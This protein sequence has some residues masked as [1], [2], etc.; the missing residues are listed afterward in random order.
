MERLK[1]IR[2]DIAFQIMVISLALICLLVV[3]LNSNQ[4]RMASPIPQ[5]ITGEYSQNGG[6]WHALDEKTNL[7][8]LEGDVVIRG[9]LNVDCLE[10][11][12]LYFYRNHIAV[13]FYVNGEDC[14]I[15]AQAYYDPIFASM[16]GEEWYFFVSTGISTED[17]VEI[18]LS[19]PHKFGNKSAY[20]DFL[21]TLYISPN[22]ADTLRHYLEPYSR[23]FM[24]AGIIF[25][26]LAMMLIGGAVAAAALRVPVGRRL[27]KIG[28]LTRFAGGYFLLDVI[29]L[30]FWSNLLV[31]NTYA[32]LLCAILFV[33]WLRLS[34]MDELT[35]Q[36]R[37]VALFVVIPA[38]LLDGLCILLS[39]VGAVLL[40]D[41][42][43]C[44]TVMQIAACLVLLACAVLELCHG[45]NGQKRLIAYSLLMITVLLDIAGVGQNLY[46]SATCTKIAFVAVAVLTLVWI[47]KVVVMD[48][49]A[50]VRAAQLERE[51]ED[52]R[53]AIMLSQIQ[54]HF[55]YN[56]LNAIYYLCGKEPE[57][58]Q[59][60]ISSFSDYLRN[61]M[62]ALEKKELIPF[63]EELQ[64]VQ[65]YLKLEKMRFGEELVVV[66]SIETSGFSLPALTVQP[67]VENAVKH[68]LSKKRGGGRVTISTFETPRCFEVVVEDDGV[69]FE[70]MKMPKNGK[71][72][73]GI[74]NVRQRLESMAGASLEITSNPGSGTT[75]VIKIPKKEKKKT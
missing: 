13:S 45:I 55:L 60:A 21:H 31:F 44:W 49:Q 51:L 17:D 23:P 65:T 30:S 42:M 19:N 26:V 15:T 72:H 36:R 46:S 58:A 35:G 5:M 29:N 16:C 10:D 40:Y 70:L 9:H 47:I 41:T 53:V 27:W 73:V 57:A 62:E 28:M 37:R 34:V 12:R 75:A 64:H 11:G 33:F 54:P 4:A 22:Q 7:S 67:L 56:V 24:V 2:W 43:F 48:H 71:A 18:R 61:N 50:S 63:D 14:C 39:F 8:A 1:K 25:F 52:S 59:E 69:G 3:V 68:G 66:Y 74:R 20:N 32:R 38:G 6:E